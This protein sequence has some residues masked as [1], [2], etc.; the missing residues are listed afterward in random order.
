MIRI[1]WVDRRDTIL[2]ADGQIDRATAD[3]G[4]T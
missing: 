4:C 3:R 2:L 1:G